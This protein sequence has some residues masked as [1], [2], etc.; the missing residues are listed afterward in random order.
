[1]RQMVHASISAKLGSPFLDSVLWFD[2]LSV[3][4]H[5]VR[6]ASRLV[7]A[8]CMYSSG[9]EADEFVVM[10]AIGEVYN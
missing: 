10:V 6:L 4:G 5:K 1:M 8:N 9:R 7:F 3:L 2:V